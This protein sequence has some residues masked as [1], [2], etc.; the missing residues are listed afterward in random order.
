MAWTFLVFISLASA[1][2]AGQATSKAEVPVEIEQ[3]ERFRQWTVVPLY[4]YSFFNKGRESWQEEDVQIYYQI[5]RQLGIGAEIDILQ[6]PPSGTDIYYSGFF[7]YYPCK[8]FE[9]HGKL[10]IS[11]SPNF[12]AKQIYSGG[13]QYQ[14]LPQLG[15]LLDYQRLNFVQ[16]PIDQLTPGLTIGFTEEISLTLRYVRGWAF[17]ELEYNYYSAALNIGLPGNAV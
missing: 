8:F 17:H 14:V 10:S 15:L 3:E 7:S 1:L 12:S 16:G 2:R 6:R 11:P 13:F 5:N 9:L 4:S